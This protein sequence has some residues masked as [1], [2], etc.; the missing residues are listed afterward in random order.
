MEGLSADRDRRRLR[1]SRATPRPLAGSHVLV[2]ASRREMRVH[3]P[4][5]AAQHEHAGRLRQPRSTRR[6]ASAARACRT[7]S[8]SSRSSAASRFTHFRDEILGE[9]P[10]FVFIEIL[11]QGSTFEMSGINGATDGADRPRRRRQLAAGGADVRAVARACEAPRRLGLNAVRNPHARQRRRSGAPPGASHGRQWPRRRRCQQQRRGERRQVAEDA[12]RGARSPRFSAASQRKNAAPSGPRPTRR[13]AAS[14]ATTARPTARA[15]RGRQRQQPGDEAEQA[16]RRGREVGDAPGQ[17][18]IA[19]PD[20]RRAERRQGSPS[21]AAG[22]APPADDRQRR[23]G[24][25]GERCARRAPAAG[26]ARQER[27]A[28]ARR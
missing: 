14:R 22:E 7:R 17:Q 16:D 15:R 4:R 20:E 1:P 25:S 12:D 11:E 19:R 9:V 24:E 2:V 28:R 10:D 13:S 6:R 27:A 26:H 8:S 21:E 3:D 5:R 18:R 23:A